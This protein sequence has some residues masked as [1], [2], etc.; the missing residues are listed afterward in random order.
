[1]KFRGDK[2]KVVNLNKRTIFLC[3]N[4]SRVH[5][6]RA[7]LNYNIELRWEGIDSLWCINGNYFIARRRAFRAFGDFRF[8]FKGFSFIVN[9]PE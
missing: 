6:I 7:E 5:P 4:D 2:T 3:L 9:F 1:M 8:S